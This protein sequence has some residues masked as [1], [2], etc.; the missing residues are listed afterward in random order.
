[1]GPILTFCDF[2]PTIPHPANHPIWPRRPPDPPEMCSSSGGFDPTW[3]RP[4]SLSSDRW[5]AIFRVGPCMLKFPQIREGGG[6]GGAQAWGTGPGESWAAWGGLDSFWGGPVAA[7]GGSW[8]R[9]GVVLGRPGAVLGRSWGH[10]G[11]LGGVL[12][13]LGARFIRIYKQSF[14]NTT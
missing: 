10:Q 7:G 2:A 3:V 9:L 4:Y 6:T 11:G 12:G 5:S 14:T 1:M 13:R 8:A